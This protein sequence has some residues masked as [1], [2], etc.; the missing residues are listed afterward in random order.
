MAEFSIKAE[1]INPFIKAT[2]E[3]FTSM[4]NLKV[5]PGKV[6]LKGP[7]GLRYDVTG[8]IGLSGGA[9]GSVAIGFPSDSASAMV[10]ALTGAETA[11]TPSMV[12]AIGELANI[13]AG[14]AKKELMQYKIS[15]S[16]PT[17]VMGEMHAINGPVDTP[18]MIVPF[19]SE[20]GSFDLALSFKSLL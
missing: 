8:I 18:C 5:S 2:M 20:C 16:L 14:A 1:H 17:V 15:I 11:S 6:R 10:R 9:I 19:A 12:D 3:T 4:V 7:D 13:I